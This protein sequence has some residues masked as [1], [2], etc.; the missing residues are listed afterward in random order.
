MAKGYWIAHID[1]TDLEGFREYIPMSTQAVTDA[2]GRFL[3]RGGSAET[4]EG[5]LRPRHVVIEFPSYAA[6][7]DCY[8]SRHY[9]AA[10]VVRQENSQAD[11]TVV[12][13]FE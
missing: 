8:R 2:G 10:R 4:V 6:A 7:L 3:V 1:V 13:G 11:I 9:A 12:E 5:D